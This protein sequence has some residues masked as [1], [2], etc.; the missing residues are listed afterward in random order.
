MDSLSTWDNQY[1][2]FFEGGDGE[3]HRV[4]AAGIPSRRVYR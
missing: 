4:G 2:L 1:L 3:E